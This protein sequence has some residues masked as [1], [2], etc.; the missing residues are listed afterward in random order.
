MYIFICIY[1]HMHIYM[2]DTCARRGGF[3]APLEISYSPGRVSLTHPHVSCD[4]FT[5]VT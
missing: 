5:Y 3:E 2:D 4:S 1:T